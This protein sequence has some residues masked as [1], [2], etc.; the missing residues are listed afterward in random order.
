[1]FFLS[2]WGYSV[3]LFTKER[4]TPNLVQRISMSYCQVFFQ[5]LLYLT[6]NSQTTS[7]ECR[8]GMACRC[9]QAA[10]E[11]FHVLHAFPMPAFSSLF[12]KRRHQGDFARQSRGRLMNV[13]A[14]RVWHS[15]A[16]IIEAFVTSTLKLFGIV[17]VRRLDSPIIYSVSVLQASGRP[18]REKPK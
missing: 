16:V 14:Q 11:C 12:S 3:H 8:P 4:F 5:S 9:F 18:A 15:S 6:L 17:Q 2:V 7:N 10:N 1:M 13:F